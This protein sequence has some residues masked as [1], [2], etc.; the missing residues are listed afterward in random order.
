VKLVR[1]SERLINEGS[2][3]LDVNFYIHSPMFLPTR[4]RITQQRTINPRREKSKGRKNTVFLTVF[5]YTVGS[6]NKNLQP[7]KANGQQVSIH[8]NMCPPLEPPRLKLREGKEKRHSS[9][10]SAAIPKPLIPTPLDH[11]HVLV[12]SAFH[13]LLVTTSRDPPSYGGIPFPPILY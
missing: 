7:M 13:I 11:L 4:C 9:I 3:C 1:I 10:Q 6:E 5:R 8:L 12:P 2:M